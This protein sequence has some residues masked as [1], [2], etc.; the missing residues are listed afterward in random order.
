MSCVRSAGPDVWRPEIRTGRALLVFVALTALGACGDDS[1]ESSATT[2]A[3]TL[4]D[5]TI[6]LDPMTVPAGRVVFD[7]SNEG[8]AVHE[9]E[10][11]TGEA[12]DISV[13]NNVAVTG[14]LELID[15]AEDIVPGMSLTLEVTL[16]AGDYVII[17]NLPGHVANG[18]VTELTVTG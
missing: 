14:S 5:E 3:A 1:P 2:V 16:D 11:F 6:S 4:T 17:C 13:V 12:T 9:F 10:V 7:I 8:D 18:M 15:E